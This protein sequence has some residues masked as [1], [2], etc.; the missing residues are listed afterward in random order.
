VGFGAGCTDWARI[1]EN[2]DT[3]E[4]CNGEDDDCD[5]VP[6]DP[7]T[8]GDGSWYVDLDSDGYGDGS[9]EETSC[10]G[11]PGMV[12]NGLDCNDSDPAVNP[13]GTEVCNDGEDNDCDGTPNACVWPSTLD[14]GDYYVVEPRCSV[15]EMG[16]R[17]VYVYDGPITAG[18]D[19][20]TASFS[21]YGEAV[22]GGIGY[23]FDF[24]DLNGDGYEDILV[25]EA[26]LERNGTIHV[27]A[28]H[29]AYGPISTTVS[30]GDLADWT[31]WG[32]DDS[33]YQSFGNVLTT[34]GDVDG[35]GTADWSAAT[36][37][38]TLDTSRQGG[39]WLFTSSGTGT[40]DA[41]DVATAWLYGTEASE[42]VGSATCG[43]DLDADGYSDW[44]VTSES[45]Q[46][47]S[48]STVSG[49]ALI[50]YG[51]V[52]GAHEP[53]DVDLIFTAESYAS[54]MSLNCQSL[55]DLNADGY[56]DFITG[57]SPTGDGAAYVIWG[58]TSLQDMAISDADIKLRGDQTPQ[59]FG[60]YTGSAGDLN[61]DG[62]T[63]I[64]VGEF[65]LQPK[66]V[67]VF[68]GPHTTRGTSYSSSADVIISGNGIDDGHYQAILAGHD[69]T[70]DGVPDMAI[71]SHF[72]SDSDGAFY[73]IPG[74]GH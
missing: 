58:S 15:G 30:S 53:S 43:A 67:Y 42:N 51:P 29:L 69:L 72:A 52:S 17:A 2:A 71:G 73:I 47:S 20:S 60:Y 57:S 13:D 14:M 4:V 21:I 33:E 34:V 44:I 74:V 16:R 68:Y 9:S 22:Y 61:E 24:V 25:A 7:P 63:D 5:G 35:D 3:P 32:P 40:D 26:G 70:G 18:T 36:H 62:W 41:E 19:P 11:G 65:G 46:A 6:D 59:Q 49:G 8:S 1:L 28:F 39:A 45:Y 56:E 48:S 37:Y 50:L 12:D 38:L 10:E 27:G 66:N 55:G 64:V 54:A 23:E 31:V